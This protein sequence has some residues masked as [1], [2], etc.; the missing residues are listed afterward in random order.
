[1]MDDDE[2]RTWEQDEARGLYRRCVDAQPQSIRQVPMNAVVD[3][4][5]TQPC[6]GGISPKT[7]DL[8]QGPQEGDDIK[9]EGIGYF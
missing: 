5:M 3:A 2:N 9:G 7:H 8:D 4:V 6:T 1:M